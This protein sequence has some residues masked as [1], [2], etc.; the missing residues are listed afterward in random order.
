MRQAEIEKIRAKNLLRIIEQDF[1]GDRA[2]FGK[3]IGVGLESV[4]KYLNHNSDRP[5]KYKKAREIEKQLELP[6]LC[7]DQQVSL[8]K[9][10]YYISISTNALYTYE[11]V[12]SLKTEDFVMECSAVLGDYDIFIKAEVES[13]FILDVLMTKIARLPGIKKC[14][15]YTSINHLRWQKPQEGHTHIREID[16]RMNCKTGLESYFQERI[17]HYFNVI[18]EL[19]KGEISVRDDDELPLDSYRIIEGTEKTIHATRELGEQMP[20]QKEYT[21][22]EA[23][24]IKNQKI[25]SQ[26]IIFFSEKDLSPTGFRKLEGEFRKYK[27]IGCHVRFMFKNQWH[28]DGVNTRWE[29]FIIVD[30]QFVCNRIDDQ[31]MMVF[32]RSPEIVQKYIERFRA[33]WRRSLEF[34]KLNERYERRS[35]WR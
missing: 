32:H 3:T 25:R 23:R 1:S 24:L 26:R 8:S 28:S 15:S 31:K 17:N 29:R 16:E 30:N 27:N 21:S 22:T 11:I 2:A 7:L 9:E 4:R 6:E 33:N 34:E 13:Y 12:K 19:E 5:L 20:G 35:G 10:I 14:K 18:K